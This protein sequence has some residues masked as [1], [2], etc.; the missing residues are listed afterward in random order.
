[1]EDTVSIVDYVTSFIARSDTRKCVYPAVAL[2]YT[3][4]A[5]AAY[6]RSLCQLLRFV[7]A[8]WS[9]Q[10]IPTAVNLGFLDSELL[11]FHSSSS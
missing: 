1:M 3:D 11:L 10:Q 9:A 2:N 5:T 7:G 6:R 4:R 8:A